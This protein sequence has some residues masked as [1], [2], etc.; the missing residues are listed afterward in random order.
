MLA[1]VQFNEESILLGFDNSCY[2][3]GTLGGGISFFDFDKDGWDDITVSSEEGEPVKFYKIS[4]DI[5]LKL[6]LELKMNYLRQK[7]YNGL[8]LIMIMI[9]TYLL[10]VILTQIYYMKISE[11]WFLMIS[12][13]R[14]D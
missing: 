3:I 2:G 1:Q 7:Q 8:I 12:P 11:I 5:F 10:Q 9:M 14:Q 6:I 4:M 13:Y